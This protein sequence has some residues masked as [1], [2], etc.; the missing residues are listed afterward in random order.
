MYV[1]VSVEQGV[2]H[3]RARHVCVRVHACA[4]VYVSPTM[5]ARL[6]IHSHEHLPEGT[7][8]WAHFPG[9]CLHPCS[10]HSAQLRMLSIKHVCACERRCSPPGR[11]LPSW[12]SPPPGPPTPVSSPARWRCRLEG[13][14]PSLASSE[15]NRDS[16][17]RQRMPLNLF[18]HVSL[19]I[20]HSSNV[21]S[22]H[23]GRCR[24]LRGSTSLFLWQCISHGKAV[25]STSCGSA[26]M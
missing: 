13:P 8:E 14:P 11:R 10:C 4:C 17:P 21:V 24:Q 6:R 16:Q 3:A 2:N 7:Q 15:Q 18:L 12:C 26:L 20:I 9:R 19:Q 22:E 25:N 1:R 5:C 23:C